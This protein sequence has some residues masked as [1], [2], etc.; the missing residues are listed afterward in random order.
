MRVEV[1]EILQLAVD[2]PLDGAVAVFKLD[3]ENGV[4]VVEGVDGVGDAEL[5]GRQGGMSERREEEEGE[6]KETD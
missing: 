4:F 6:E 2:D 1:N 3:A 5:C